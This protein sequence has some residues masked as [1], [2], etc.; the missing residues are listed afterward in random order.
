MM[1][2]EFNCL[3]VAGGWLDQDPFICATFRLMSNIV[4][5]EEN[6]RNKKKR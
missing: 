6:K 2:K 4:A 3:P 5:E 1:C